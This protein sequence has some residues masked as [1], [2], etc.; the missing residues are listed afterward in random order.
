WRRQASCTWS[1]K[2][3]KPSGTTKIRL[4]RRRS[5]SNFMT[6]KR[7]LSCWVLTIVCLLIVL[8]LSIGVPRLSAR[9]LIP[10]NSLSRSLNKPLPLS[11]AAIDQLMREALTKARTRVEAQQ[12]DQA[13]GYIPHG[14]N[15]ALRDYRGLEVLLSGPAGTGKTR[16]VLEWINHLA[17]RYPG[18]RVLIVRKTRASLAESVLY[19]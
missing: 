8:S 9:G 12:V 13:R 4:S 3:S 5:R 18:L 15:A 17:W 16:G 11:Q 2:P 7:R 14:A 1:K 19:T 6:H 10:I